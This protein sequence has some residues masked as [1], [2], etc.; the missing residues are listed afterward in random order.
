MGRALSRYAL[1]LAVLWSMQVTAAAAVSPDTLSAA[2][3]QSDWST[4]DQIARELDAS[5]GGDFFSAYV[6]ASQLIRSGRCGDAEPLLLLMRLT[7]PYFLPVYELSFVCHKSAGE[8]EAALGDLDA[9]LAALPEGPQRDLVAQIRQNEASAGRPTV[10]VYGDVMPSTNV[11]RQ[12]SAK[13][14]GPLTITDASRGHAGLHAVG[15][16]AI[17]RLLLERDALSVTGV[18]KGELGYTTAGNLLEPR[19]IAEAPITFRAPRHVALVLSPTVS[20]GFQA[21]RFES[22]SVGTQFVAGWDVTETKNIGLST[23]LSY[24]HFQS[25]PY[26]DGI[27][28]DGILSGSTM[29]GPQTR[30][31]ASFEADLDYTFDKDFRTLDVSAGAHVDQILGNGLVLGAEV[32]IGR[33]FHSSPPPL[34]S[35]PNQTDSYVSARLEVSHRAFT[36]GPFMPAVYYQYRNQWSDNVFY[37]YQSHDIGVSLKAKL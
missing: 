12:T 3:V 17:S 19:F 13:S 8:E 22:V 1:L 15:G 5:D 9:L 28:L 31:S 24:R 23:S 14:L 27:E 29:L 10:S 18:L 7:R 37:T 30:L 4:A 20:L 32:S 2:I 11:D 16:V 35:G 21:L 33:V 6:K 25:S 26:R 36:I 34:S